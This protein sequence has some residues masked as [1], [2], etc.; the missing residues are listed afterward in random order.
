M[1]QVCDDTY[2]CLATET[3]DGGEDEEDCGS[4]GGEPYF[5]KITISFLK[6]HQRC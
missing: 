6:Q 1:M 2:D 5:F 3:S 4:G